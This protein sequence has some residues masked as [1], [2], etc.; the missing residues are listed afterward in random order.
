MS[1]ATPGPWIVELDPDNERSW[2]RQAPG[3]STAAYWIAQ[4]IGNADGTL[5]GQHNAALIAAAPTLRDAL[6]ACL[7]AWEPLLADADLDAGSNPA[8][9]AIQH[10]KAA[11]EGL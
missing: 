7:K 4:T 11:L 3:G 9:L 5:E 6:V 1:K 8:W 10:A 2:I